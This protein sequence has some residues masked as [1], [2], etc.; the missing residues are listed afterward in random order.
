MA[1]PA[2]ELLARA[3][4]TWRW[5]RC[6]AALW[7][8]G[9]DQNTAADALSNEALDSAGWAGLKLPQVPQPPQTTGG[10]RLPHTSCRYVGLHKGYDRDSAA[11]CSLYPA[12]YRGPPPP[13][14]QLPLCWLTQGSR[15][16][17]CRGLQSASSN[18]VA[19]CHLFEACA[20][21]ARVHSMLATGRRGGHPIQPPRH[22]AAHIG[23]RQGRQPPARQRRA[24]AEAAHAAAPGCVRRPHRHARN[25][26][27]QFVCMHAVADIS[28]CWFLLGNFPRSIHGQCPREGTNCFSHVNPLGMPERRRDTL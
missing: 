6:K 8:A 19:Q 18:Q 13:A 15:S 24:R 22:T 7:G 1:A 28:L 4:C 9:R 25:H 3:R 27:T 20:M 14:H 16:N 17:F 26:N 12:N 11:D 10:P 21:S 23:G 5:P 2:L